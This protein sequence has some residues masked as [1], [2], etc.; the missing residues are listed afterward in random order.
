MMSFGTVQFMEWSHG[1]ES[2]IGF[3]SGMK[4]DLEFL[5]RIWF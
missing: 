2:W 5:V 4:S 1:V 3:C